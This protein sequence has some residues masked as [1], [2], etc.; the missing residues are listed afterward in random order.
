MLK[1]SI[2]LGVENR[3]ALSRSLSLCVCVCVV[4][5]AS[6]EVTESELKT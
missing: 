1:S 5:R 3:V 4:G 6:F 2:Y